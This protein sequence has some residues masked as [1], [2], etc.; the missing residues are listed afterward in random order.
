MPL[1]VAELQLLSASS[2]D[3]WGVRSTIPS[4]GASYLIRIDPSMRTFQCVSLESDGRGAG[5]AALGDDRAAILTENDRLLI[6]TAQRIVDRWELPGTMRYHAPPWSRNLVTAADDGAYV[7][8]LK[9]G[10]LWRYGTRKT[11]TLE[12]R[13][14]G[15]PS[16]ITMLPGRIAAVNTDAAELMTVSVP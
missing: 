16:W 9:D 2:H 5:L 11:I 13:F 3:L 15:R 1:F 4:A 14:P 7:V 10:A 6:S 12:A 8:S